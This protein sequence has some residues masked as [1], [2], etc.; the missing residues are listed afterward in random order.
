MTNEQHKQ[1]HRVSKTEY[2]HM[3]NRR[4]YLTLISMIFPYELILEVGL[5]NDDDDYYYYYCYS[6]TMK[7][8]NSLHSSVCR[9]VEI[10]SL[11]M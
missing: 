10:N 9:F 8:S 6:T 7:T 1:Q 2:L 4:I 11:L 3:V 5:Y